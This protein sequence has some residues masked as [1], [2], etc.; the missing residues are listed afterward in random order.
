MAAKRKAWPKQLSC[1]QRIAG[2]A[3]NCDGDLILG[4]SAPRAASTSNGKN[5]RYVEHLQFR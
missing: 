3:S 4:T 1:F 2:R 5:D